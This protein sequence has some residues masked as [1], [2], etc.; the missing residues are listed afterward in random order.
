MR[1]T[2]NLNIRTEKDVKDA[3]EQI[4]N[5]LG[6]NMTT[7]INIFLRQ[8][9]RSNG[10]QFELKLNTPNE[11]TIE[12]E[13]IHSINVAESDI[14]CDCLEPQ[15]D[16]WEVFK[17]KYPIL[18]PFKG[19][20]PYV[21]IKPVDLQLLDSAYYHLS[22]NSFLMHNFY[23]YKHLIL[24]KYTWEKGTFFYVGVP[25][26]FIK[27]EQNAAAMFPGYTIEPVMTTEVAY[28][29]GNIHCITQQMPKV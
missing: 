3:A 2:T 6:L 18:Y 21:S 9:I 22:N 24:G 19:Q 17:K 29:G 15:P 28:G 10:I 27:K 4:F 1:T 16:K 26:E 7:A 12:A 20:G 14:L 23:K 8:T 11:K 25:G 13:V 5:E